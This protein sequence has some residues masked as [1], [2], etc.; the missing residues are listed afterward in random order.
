MVLC[1]QERKGEVIKE[2][3]KSLFGS[4]DPYN[5]FKHGGKKI[6]NESGLKLI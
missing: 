5:A 2:S 3:K 6:L 1:I 4:S